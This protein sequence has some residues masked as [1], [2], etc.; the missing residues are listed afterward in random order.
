DA[1][2]ARRAAAAY[3]LGRAGGREHL[4]L[5]HKLL[6]DPAPA[7]C[8]RAAQGL[9]AAKDKNAIPALIALLTDAREQQLFQIEELLHHVAGSDAPQE[10]LS[11]TSKEAREPAVKT[12]QKW[13]EA[14]KDQLDLTRLGDNESYLGLMTVVEYDSEARGRMGRVWEAGRDGKPRW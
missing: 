2:P 5:L 3:A 10:T 11:G 12:W 7:V 14:R 6:K 4:A 1:L 13:Y 9:L 8:F